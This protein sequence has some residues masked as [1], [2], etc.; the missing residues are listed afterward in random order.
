MTVYNAKNSSM[1]SSSSIMETHQSKPADEVQKPD[2]GP[3]K[4]FRNF[5][6]DTASII[7]AMDPAFSP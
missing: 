4:S 6:F 5:R 1:N 7:Q 2:S 3:G